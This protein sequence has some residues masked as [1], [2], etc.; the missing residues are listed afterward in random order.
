MLYFTISD[1]GKLDFKFSL[2]LVIFVDNK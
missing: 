1:T 2:S